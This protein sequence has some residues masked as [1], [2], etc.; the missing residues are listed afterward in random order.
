[1][2]TF[3][4]I[5]SQTSQ[6]RLSEGEHYRQNEMSLKKA[7]NIPCVYLSEYSWALYPVLFILAEELHVMHNVWWQTVLIFLICDHGLHEKL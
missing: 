6:I 4:S 5:I 2:L 7:L 1:M 3:F